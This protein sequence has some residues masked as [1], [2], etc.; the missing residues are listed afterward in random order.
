MCGTVQHIYRLMG[1]VRKAAAEVTWSASAASVY[2]LHA[3][4][5]SFGAMARPMHHGRRGRLARWSRPGHPRDQR[6]PALLP[7]AGPR[8]AG[9]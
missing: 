4:S 9:R 1:H 5:I 7:A 6:R 3:P 8:T 2:A